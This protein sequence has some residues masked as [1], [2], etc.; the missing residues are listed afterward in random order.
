M[1]PVKVLVDFYKQQGISC[2]EILT[3]P[4]FKSLS[5]DQQVD[6]LRK[7]GAEIQSGIKPTSITR[8]TL[9]NSGRGALVGAAVITPIAIRH[10]LGFPVPPP[11][12]RPLLYGLAVGAGAAVGAVSGALHGR[13]E[14]RNKEQVNK[15]LSALADDNKNSIKLLSTYRPS[16]SPYVPKHPLIRENAALAHDLIQEFKSLYSQE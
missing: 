4:V 3:D 11:M 15:Y 8:S 1:N 16:G 2:E 9:S 6:A 13:R 12:N 5:L 14:Q 7:Y 10:A